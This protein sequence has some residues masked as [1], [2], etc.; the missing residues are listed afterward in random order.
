MSHA[1]RIGQA[2]VHAVIAQ[3]ILRGH[4]PLIP[5]FDDRGVDLMTSDGIRI[6]VKSSTLRHC[7]P[8]EEGGGY[9]F[10]LR[11]RTWTGGDRCVSL[12]R[13]LSNE[14]E[15]LILWGIDQNRFWI[16]PTADKP[17]DLSTIRIS[18][19]ANT[20]YSQVD[21][22]RVQ[23]L[24]DCGL[25]SAAIAKEMGMTVHQL[26]LRGNASLNS[27]DPERLGG[28][29]KYAKYEDAWHLLSEH[30]ALK[31]IEASSFSG[32][33]TADVEAMAALEREE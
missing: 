2:G 14:C 32:S 30:I 7:A 26:R 17:G 8:F 18:S 24:R 19:N 28:Q 23:H 29:F 27:M 33:A 6:Q 5:A 31:K 13:N 12:K 16:I 9:G 22:G 11:K 3:L 21:F 10:N 25:S 1:I 15:F 20:R 4:T